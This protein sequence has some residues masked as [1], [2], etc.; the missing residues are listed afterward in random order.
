MQTFLWSLVEKLGVYKGPPWSRFQGGGTQRGGNS[1]LTLLGGALGEKEPLPPLALFIPCPFSTQL[2]PAPGNSITPMPSSSLHGPSG[3]PEHRFWSQPNWFPPSFPTYQLC[4][5]GQVPQ[6]L[7][8]SVSSSTIALSPGGP[9]GS[10]VS[11]NEL[12]VS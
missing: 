1:P 12:Q 6:L 9:R 11:S 3:F 10:F 5:L 2:T 8:A 7:C 4:D